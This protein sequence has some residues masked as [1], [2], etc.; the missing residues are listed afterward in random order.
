MKKLLAA[1]VLLSSQ[2]A[3]AQFRYGFELGGAYNK[4]TDD[5]NVWGATARTAATIG[6]QVGLVGDY[7]LTENIYVQPGVFFSMKSNKETANKMLNIPIAVSGFNVNATGTIA[8]TQKSKFNY[9]EVPVNI[10]YKWGQA[11]G[12]RFYVGVAPYV[13]YGIGG[14]QR[15]TQNISAEVSSFKL[16]DSTL[17]NTGSKTFANDSFGYKTLDY[18]FKICE[19]YEFAGGFFFRAEFGLGL[20]N[21]SNYPDAKSQNMSF[22]LNIG[23]LFGDKKKKL[24]G[25]Q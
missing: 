11:G 19:G 5:K 4:M 9:V 25:L 6:G 23:Y 3:F 14:K 24:Q 21:L 13:A 15:V 10:L 17:R 1:L 16:F 12:G 22:A 2:A 18:G 8:M 7:G 20:S